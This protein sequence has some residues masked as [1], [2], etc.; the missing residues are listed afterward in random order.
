MS[1][2]LNKPSWEVAVEEQ[3]K[4]T[5]VS[6]VKQGAAPPA[7][8]RR[9]IKAAAVAHGVSTHFITSV[10]TY[11]QLFQKLLRHLDNNGKITATT[12]ETFKVGPVKSYSLLYDHSGTTKIDDEVCFVLEPYSGGAP[13]KEYENQLDA[14]TYALS[15]ILG[16]CVTWSDASWHNPPFT[17]RILF[18]ED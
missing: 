5:G 3:R 10:S 9:K 6:P 17:Y 4:K 18:E 16:C 11:S 13:K 7:W 2:K 12:G 14:A 8:L 1:Q 15:R